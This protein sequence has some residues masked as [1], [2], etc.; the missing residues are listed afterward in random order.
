MVQSKVP[1]ELWHRERRGREVNHERPKETP[2]YGLSSVSSSVIESAVVFLQFYKDGANQAGNGFFVNVPGADK[3][4]IL[5][6]GHNLIDEAKNRTKDL[7]AWWQGQADWLKITDD[8]VRISKVYEAEPT[9]ASAVSDFGVILLPKPTQRGE[10]RLAFGFS[11]KLA[12]EDE[13]PTTLSITSYR[14][15]ANMGDRPTRSSGSCMNPIMNKNQLE[16]KVDTE[17]GVSGSAVWLGYN[18]YPTVVAIHN[19]G[20]RRKG[21]HYGSRGTRLNLVVLREIFDWAGVYNA[22]KHILAKSVSGPE[23]QHPLRFVYS[24]DDRQLRIVVGDSDGQRQ[25]LQRFDML[26]VY[27][28]PVVSPKPPSVEY[29]FSQVDANGLRHWV[30]WDVD[31]ESASLASALNRARSCRW[32]KKGKSGAAAMIVQWQGDLYEVIVKTDSSVVKPWDLDFPGAEFSGVAFQK[33]GDA[34]PDSYK[35]FVL[36]P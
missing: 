32:E 19:Y 22:D 27:S 1:R 28:A 18:K 9:A 35:R 33:Q 30:S 10:V 11:L 24:P 36:E 20:P 23:P 5:T 15:N 25:A 3:D 21:V 16:Y 13:L 7:K 4:V 29:G 12:E 8:M 31:R 34:T 26:P 2:L 6:A 14:A 17:A